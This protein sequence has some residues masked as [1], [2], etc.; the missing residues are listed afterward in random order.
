LAG[1]AN[2][3][4]HLSRAFGPINPLPFGWDVMHRIST[5]LLLP[6]LL[7]AESKPVPKFPVGKETT[8]VSGPL[9]KEGYVDYEAA[10]NDRYGKGIAPEKNAT[11]LLWKALGPT[12]EG[13]RGMPAE[14]FKRLGIEAPPNE[15]TY[16]IGLP[17]YAK[18]HLSLDKSA[19]D[20]IDEQ[21]WRATQRPWTAKD[22]PHL[23]AWLKANEKPLAVIVEATRRP[24]YFNPLVSRRIGN[25]RAGLLGTL[26]QGVQKCSELAKALAAR[27]M[28]QTGEGKFDEAWLDLLACHRLSRLVGQGASLIEAL[29]GIAIDRNAC[30]ADLAYLEHA[31]LT[32]RQIQDRLKILQGLSPLPPLADAIDL[33]ERFTYLESVQQIPRYGTRWLMGLSNGLT[34]MPKPSSEEAKVLVMV[35]WDSALRNGNRWYDRLAAA[36]RLPDRPERERELTKIDEDLKALKQAAPRLEDLAKLL[37]GNDPPA[38]TA[39]KLFGDVFIGL[40]LPPTRKVQTAHDQAEQVQRN[41]HVAFALAAYHRDHGRY[42]AQLE[43]LAP[44]YMAAIPGDLFSGKALVY[45]PAEAG[46]LLYSVGVNGK[47]EGG[48]GFDDD[49][50][51][52]DLGV[53]MPLPELKRKR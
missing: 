42:P 30:G 19:S 15:G 26:D 9:D 34:K 6:C 12:P 2:Q 22:Y 16:F 14:F 18:D 37:R 39:G 41:L 17:S 45:R 43:N 31:Q 10:L 21:Q 4:N 25:E 24:V 32:S 51:G 33:S 40:L 11:V 50:P 38:K 53:R 48:R 36:L 20:Q 7:A 3:R 23:V 5:L 52:D 27:A 28:L 44:K 47:D 46:C 29:V 13:R 49:P 35:D 1:A 8:Y